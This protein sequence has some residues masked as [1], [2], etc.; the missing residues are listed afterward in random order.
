MS[1]QESPAKDDGL[2]AT[3]EKFKFP[4]HLDRFQLMKWDGPGETPKLVEPTDPLFSIM[5]AHAC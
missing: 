1:V 5:A 3:V 4:N 2:P